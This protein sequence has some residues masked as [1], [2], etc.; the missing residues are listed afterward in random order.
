[1]EENCIRDSM[2]K[3]ILNETEPLVRTAVVSL[4]FLSVHQLCWHKLL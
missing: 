3:I 2:S 4:Q 1:M